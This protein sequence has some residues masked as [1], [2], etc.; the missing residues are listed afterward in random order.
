MIR[1]SRQ[2][3]TCQQAEHYYASEYTRG[4]YYASDRAESAGTWCGQGAERLGLAG[5]V[6]REDFQAL[7]LGLAP[8]GTVLV[9]PEAAS[10]KHRAAWDF[11]ASPDKSVSLVALLGGDDRVR[12]AHL[13]A[14]DLAF[15]VLERHARTKTT[16]RELITT[17]NL[18]AARFDHD[19]SRELDPQLHSHYVLFN[20]TERSPGEWRALETREIYLA[21]TLATAVYHAE[22]AR[23][24]QALGYR[25]AA[26]ARGHVR[27]LGIPPAALAHFSKRRAQILAELARQEGRQVPDAQQA[28]L[29]TRRRKDHDVDR[30]ALARL[31][32]AAA[33]EHGIDFD[34]L[35]RD[36]AARVASGRHLPAG[37]PLGQA[38]ASV[39]WAVDHLTERKAVLT[40]RELE[41]AALRHVAGRGA[42]AAEVRAALAAH[43]GLIRDSRD[44]I[45]TE[46][47]LRLELANVAILREGLAAQA[48]PIL[49]RPY[50]GE[51]R[52][53]HPDQL[54]V[55]RHVLESRAQVLAVEGK[56]GT[57]K[58]YT[59]EAIREAAQEAR[60]GV[61]GYAVSTGAV[62]ELAKVGLE[63]A[64]IK[65]LELRTPLPAPR[66]L[67]I[68]D[69]AGLMSNRHAATVL[70]KARAAGARLVLVGDRRQHHA[71]EAGKPFAVLQRHGLRA[72][73]LDTI[74]RQKTPD[75][76]AA[77]Q[78]SADGRAREALARLDASGH[79]V[80]IVSRSAR[81]AAMV[82]D[83]VGS[84]R[85]T[86]MIAPSHAERRDLNFQARRALIAAG[87]I[88]PV[89]V[90]VEVAVGKGVTGAERADIRNYE[91]GDH[92]TYH[93]DAPTQGVKRGDTARVLAVDPEAHTLRVERHR[94]GAVFSYDPRR[95]RG[96]DLAR[97]ETRELAPGDRIQFR[98]AERSHGIVNGAMATVCSVEPGGP[99][100]VRLDGRKAA[101][102]TLDPARGPLA[103]DHG[104]AMTAH[105]AQGSTVRNVLATI[106]TTHSAEL[107]NRQQANVTISRATHRVTIF[108][109]DRTALPAAVDRQPAKSS[110][111]DLRR[112]AS[113]ERS[114]HAPEQVPAATAQP[115]REPAGPGHPV[116]AGGP[117][118]PGV[119]DRATPEPARSAAAG[120]T[121]AGPETTRGRAQGRDARPRRGDRP[122][123]AHFARDPAPRS[124]DRRRPGREP[125]APRPAERLRAFL[126]PARWSSA[127]RLR[128][129]PGDRA[130]AR[131]HFTRERGNR[132]APS[133]AQRLAAAV[134]RWQAWRAERD[135]LRQESHALRAA[136]F[137][138]GREPTPAAPAGA[139]SPR[140]RA[141]RRVTERLA[142]LNR[143]GNPERELARLLD[144]I[145]WRKALSLLPGLAL[146]AGRA[147]RQL[148]RLLA[149]LGHER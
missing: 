53:L 56:P 87:Q 146:S 31:W 129:G 44:R 48:P 18:V 149:D 45:T 19:T 75:L 95:L 144:E 71:V 32:A 147:L 12:A 60:W 124:N 127:L 101:L 145:G 51:G 28:A 59:L 5:P 143:P 57:G 94:D 77:V 30:A 7:L 70:A 112:A 123:R 13:R 126:S 11:V 93:R 72:A 88:S 148:G 133:P 35:R 41:T 29:R 9:A 40:A 125:R 80:E 14:A 79:V 36:A 15:A 118:R 119:P 66:Q 84:P 24:L 3:L 106:D 139:A 8:D 2:P 128:R 135:A 47:T 108:T 37:D 43:P 39:A 107:V 113:P 76:L 68:V 109:N 82:R 102:V 49:D 42:G 25:V 6:A 90:V 114:A 27:I 78:L 132:P 21:Q 64:T 104:Y 120:R 67:W 103:L 98:R 38:A 134:A 131:R 33:A 58:T 142:A 85:D 140:D 4:D 122:R 105:A 52:S 1:G 50:T 117:D 16:S 121:A 141:L 137:Q 17:A 73:R 100:A 91:V 61:R 89:A 97:V 62:A 74:Q 20:L 10:G 26:N 63:A 46:A 96:V 81:H 55:A 34:A 83:Y 111:L 136:A 116:R 65:A 22:I 130:D 23:D 54:R 115:A 69:E 92:V 138:A 86:L 110:A 99:L